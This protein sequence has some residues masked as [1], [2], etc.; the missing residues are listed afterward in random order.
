MFSFSARLNSLVKF[1]RVLR[2]AGAA[3]DVRVRAVAR[4]DVRRAAGGGRAD[5][6]AGVG[7]V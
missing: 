6:R 5:A 7:G 2:G 4:S 3:G 1:V